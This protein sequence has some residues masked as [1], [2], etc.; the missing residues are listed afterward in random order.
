MTFVVC[1]PSPAICAPIG[2][3]AVRQVEGRPD[4]EE[5]SVALITIHAS[6]GLEWPIV[7]PINMIGT[8]K[9]ESGIMHDRRS[10]R[11]SIPV[12]GV[13][14][15]DYGDIKAWTAEELERERVRLWHVAATRARSPHSAATL[16]RA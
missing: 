11:F 9:S 3:E 16:F 15:A 10:D 1:A 5:Q 4:A 8:P 2:E 7:I 14:P 12:F 6:K 13:E